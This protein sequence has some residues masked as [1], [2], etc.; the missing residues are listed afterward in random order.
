MQGK[1]TAPT[2]IGPRIILTT[3]RDK[4]VGVRTLAEPAFTDPKQATELIKK[5]R[6]AGR[7]IVS[8]NPDVVAILLAGSRIKGTA[9]DSSDI[10]LVVVSRTLP[11]YSPVVDYFIPGC[12]PFDSRFTNVKDLVS[13]EGLP[14]DFCYQQFSVP[15]SF[16]LPFDAISSVYGLYI[17]SARA[18]YFNDLQ[19]ALAGMDRRQQLALKLKFLTFIL[20][21]DPTSQVFKR[22]FISKLVERSGLSEHEV[23]AIFDRETALSRSINCGIKDQK[24]ESGLLEQTRDS[25]G[26]FLIR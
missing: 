6:D 25:L 12:L 2:Y 8:K 9:L 20:D 26:E 10:D 13:F 11:P 19:K 5:L 4:L 1:T 21:I 18:E 24:T 15:F 23:K 7:N 22:I 14:I 16:T 3:L 17:L